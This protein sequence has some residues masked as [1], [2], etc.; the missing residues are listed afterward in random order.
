MAKDLV[1]LQRSLL[2]SPLSCLSENFLSSKI[3]LNKT[4]KRSSQKIEKKGDFPSREDIGKVWENAM[5]IQSVLESI[6][7]D[8]LDKWN[9]K[10][11]F[12]LHLYCCS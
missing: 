10:V 8:V 12:F 4:K 5:N 7:S 2:E 11:V 1:S 6:E 3:K 9:R